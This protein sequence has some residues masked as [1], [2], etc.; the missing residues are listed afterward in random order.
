[1]F[2]V[3]KSNYLFRLDIYIYLNYLQTITVK[4]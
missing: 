3:T 4:F 2:I 1:M